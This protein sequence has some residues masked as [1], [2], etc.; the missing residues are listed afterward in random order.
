MHS[1]AGTV[2]PAAPEEGGR[3]QVWWGAGEPTAAAL[4]V[5]ARAAGRGHRVHVLRVGEDHPGERA[6]AAALPGMSYERA[7]HDSWQGALENP[8]AARA[9]AALARARDLL[10]ACTRADLRAPLALGATPEEGVHVL[11][12][13]GVLDAVERGLVTEADVRALAEGKPA[14]LELLLT[15]GDERP[16]VAEVAD[17][18][19]TVGPD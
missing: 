13:G 17:L 1:T 12:V 10:E 6:V 15:G 16:A 4:G 5:G 19:S 8:D 9:E 14:D 18:V 2:E 11:V 7:G 3:V